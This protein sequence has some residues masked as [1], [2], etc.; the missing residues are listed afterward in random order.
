MAGKAGKNISSKYLVYHERVKT[1][2]VYIRDATPVSPYALILFGGGKMEVERGGEPNE[3]VFRLDGWLGFKC[4]RRDHLLVMEL[5]EVLDE[6]LRHKVENPKID[7]SEEAAGVVEAVKEI[8][9]LEADGKAVRKVREFERSG[10]G[11]HESAFEALKRT[12]N[13]GKGQGKSGGGGSKSGG[14]GRSG[15]GSSRNGNSGGGNSRSGAGSKRS[16]GGG[17]GSRR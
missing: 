14:S 12:S 6:I 13:G 8:L 2:R 7:F 5:R 10:G 4:P 17:G 16:G 15:G 9:L 11:G 3:S 1:T